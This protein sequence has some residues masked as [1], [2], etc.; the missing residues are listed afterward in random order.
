MMAG[1]ATHPEIDGDWLGVT[2]GTCFFR[3]LAKNLFGT[4][5]PS[6]EVSGTVTALVLAPPGAVVPPL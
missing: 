1:V 5:P 2:G 6:N 3:V 4:S